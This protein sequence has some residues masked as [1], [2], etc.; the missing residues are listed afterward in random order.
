VHLG[1]QRLQALLVAHAEAVLLVDDDEAEVLEAHV[2][3]QQP[4]R[5]DD[6][7]D[8]AALEPPRRHLRFLAGAEARQR[9]D[10]HRPVGEAVAE[11]A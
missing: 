1:A 10:A 6:D 8:R 11:V 5:A 7:V 2:G 3:V 4:V 9:L